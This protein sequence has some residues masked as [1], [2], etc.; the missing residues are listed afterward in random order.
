MR[1]RRLNPALTDLSALVGEWSV[2][3]ALPAGPS[4]PVRGRV[5]VDWWEG[6]AFLVICAKVG[7]SGPAGSVAVIGRDAAAATNTMLYDDARGDP[8]I[9]EMS[10][11]AGVWMQR[12][13]APVLSQ[14]FT[15]TFDGGDT[16]AA[17]WER[18]SDGA[19]WEH[20]LNLTYM[21]V[22]RTPRPSTSSRAK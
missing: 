18:S 22:T 1:R 3:I 8:R 2:E 21:R 12:R 11:G 6:G 17:R 13:S 14:R 19:T 5:E 4:S 15:G 16:I 7:W 20:D 10:F 9:Y